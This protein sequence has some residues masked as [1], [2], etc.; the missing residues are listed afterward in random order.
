MLFNDVGTAPGFWLEE[1]GKM[2]AVLPG[3]PRELAPMFEEPVS[4][5]GRRCA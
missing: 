4:K 1:K 5:K 2:L 3:P